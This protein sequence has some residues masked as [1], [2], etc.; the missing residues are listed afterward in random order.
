MDPLAPLLRRPAVVVA[1]FLAVAAA[2][3]PGLLRFRFDNPPE[4]FFVR[5]ADA[6]ERYRDFELAFGRDRTVRLL[7]RGDGLWTPAGLEW[8]AELEERATALRGVRAAAGPV[9]HH[10]WSGEEGVDAGP[11][12]F[13]KLLLS[14]PLD[15]RVGWI[16][17]RGS[18]LSVL[19]GLYRLP[20]PAQAATVDG[21]RR[22]LGRAPAGVETALVGLPVFQVALDRSLAAMAL[23]LFP[24]LGGLALAL[25]LVFF[26][27]LAGVV[28]PLGPVA[29]ALAVPLGVMG[30]FRVPLDL[31][32]VLLPALLCV[33]ALATAVHVLVRFRQHRAE[34]AG[35]RAAVLETYR[36]KAAPVLWTGVTT[37]VGFGSLALSRVPAVRD[38][39]AWAAFG[40][41]FL[42]LVSLAFYPAWLTVVTGAGHRRGERRAEAPSGGP[43]TGGAAG[44]A[45]GR[46]VAALAVRRRRAVLLAF[47][48][49]A[50]GLLVGAGRLRA[51]S[52]L[53]GYLPPGHPVR[54]DLVAA[55]A[56]GVPAVVVELVVAGPPG[57]DLSRPQ[58]LERLA[59]LSHALRQGPGSLGAL[60]AADLVDDA[61]RHRSVGVSDRAA[62]GLEPTPTATE[63]RRG[64]EHLRSGRE[65]SL[66]LS[67]F[68]TPD[69]E[70]ARVSLFVPLSGPEEMAPIIASARA[71]AERRF[72]RSEVVVTGQFPMV[73]AAQRSLLETVVLSLSLT[74]LCVAAVFRLTAGGVPLTL[75][76]LAP[77][78]WPV[79]A[80][81]GLMGWTG[82]GL[83]STTAIIAAVV[84]GLAVDDTF[85]TL[86]DFRSLAGGRPAPTAARRAVGRLAGAH[87]ATA[88]LLAAGFAAVGTVDVVPV[89]RFGRLAAV[90][91][92][93]ALAADLLLAPALLAGAS[94]REVD[95]LTRVQRRGSRHR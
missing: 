51:G 13:R 9:G 35:V 90:A 36:V 62:G 7:A 15:R 10:R 74:L 19:V 94:R 20:G 37:A 38:L 23:R 46:R 17:E 5:D 59:G 72:P 24:L 28:V 44:P 67:T 52:D 91:V 73:L 32:T 16:D 12:A 58:A 25:L 86:G 77:N 34:G 26:R 54:A 56:R 29:V 76:L 71:E 33:V 30:W 69:G 53:A 70:R 82:V 27:D 75:R 14:D 80:V 87:A 31:V 88:L 66:L 41:A 92:L 22:L 4:R 61:A 47:G 60:S 57:A 84:L 8:F 3:A 64:L 1:L 45:W 2:A 18:G 11:E 48:L 89:A 50:A 43:A 55:E 49:L 78:L 68:L 95:R 42:T 40:F 79:A 39:G 63:R 93:A 65:S 21:L 83:E 85:H 81:L 6:L